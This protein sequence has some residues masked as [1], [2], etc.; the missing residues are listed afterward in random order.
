M[1]SSNS[2][3]PNVWVGIY[4]CSECGQVIVSG[5]A[6]SKTLIVS[7]HAELAGS[8][9]ESCQVNFCCGRAGHS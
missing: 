7:V 8:V 9:C 3:E 1:V 2:S 5:P 4:V 6:V